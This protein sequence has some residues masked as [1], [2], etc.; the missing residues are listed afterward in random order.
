MLGKRLKDTN[1]GGVA[2]EKPFQNVVHLTFEE[3]ASFKIP[4]IDN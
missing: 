3:S 1:C 2:L 4:M